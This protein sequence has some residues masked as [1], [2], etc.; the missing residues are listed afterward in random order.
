MGL[1]GDLESAV[2]QHTGLEP[3]QAQRVVDAVLGPMRLA[4][5]P[6][7]TEVDYPCGHA[8]WS[9]GGEWLFCVERDVHQRH[10]DRKAEHWS[11]NNPRDVDLRRFEGA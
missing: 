1:Y 8:Y 11:S 6:D 5:S 2:I 10:M 7:W 4:A 9:S 3:E